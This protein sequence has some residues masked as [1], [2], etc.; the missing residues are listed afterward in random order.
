MNDQNKTGAP[1]PIHHN[2]KTL[3]TRS[4]SAPLGKQTEMGLKS[5]TTWKQRS[6]PPC[7][8][9]PNSPQTQGA[10]GKR[11]QRGSTLLSLIGLHVRTQYPP[12]VP[13]PFSRRFWL[14][15]AE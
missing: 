2:R 13:L 12:W 8:A 15:P 1:Q 7:P 3:K 9:H 11:S 10:A 4:T 6:L 5:G 14:S